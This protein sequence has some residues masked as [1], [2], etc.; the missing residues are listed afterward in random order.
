MIKLSSEQKEIVEA[1]LNEAVQVLASAGTGKTRVLT[2][3]IRFILKNTKRKRVIAITFTNK[4][5]QEM[6]SRLS[7]CNE[8]VER[9]WISTIHSFAEGVLRS[10]GHEIGLPKQ[11]QIFER[12]KDRMDIFIHALQTNWID[13]Y[14]Y[15]NLR[16]K[17]NKDVEYELREYMNAFSII[18]RELMDKT[19]VQLH[20]ADK[21][22]LWQI[23]QDYQLALLDSG[24]IDYDDLIVYALKLFQNEPW[25]VDIYRIMYKY[26]C[27][28]EAQDLNLLQYEFLKALCGDSIKSVMMVGDPNQMIYGFNGSSSTYLSKDF[29][30]DF[31]A[32]KFTLEQNYRSSQLI[33]HAANNLKPDAVHEKNSTII[34]KVVIKD[35]PDPIEEAKWII[36]KINQ[37]ITMGYHEEIEGNITL[38]R[39][40]VIARNRLV[41]SDLKK[42]LK[43][44]SIPY[45]M[46]KTDRVT[47]PLSSLGKILDYGIRV[48]LNPKDW[49]HG[50]KLCSVLSIE[51][52]PKWNDEDILKKFAHKVD[53][54][55]DSFHH[56]QSELLL[57]IHELDSSVPNIRK[58]KNVMYQKLI[59]LADRESAHGHDIERS[60]QELEEFY[61]NWMMFKQNGSTSSL[62]SFQSARALGNGVAEN[63]TNDSLMLSTV[64]TMK[65]LEKDIVFII[66]MCEGTFP[67]YRASNEHD[68]SEERN[69]AFVA[70]TRAKRWLF[71]SYPEKRRMPWGS[72]RS[73]VE[74]RFIKE[75][76]GENPTKRELLP[77]G[78]EKKH[79]VAY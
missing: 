5:A 66:S 4:A 10:Y 69:N 51:P 59:D 27:V 47:E 56:F 35:Q 21:P 20:F 64:H 52:P 36:S 6:Q 19:E 57:C 31:S 79:E 67:D 53:T 2:E 25:I 76:R 32:R 77:L 1:P 39:M 46:K 30:R 11:L 55:N 37:F 48:K 12:D 60:I 62:Y 75:I 72:E 63:V 33:I 41:F 61:S 68:I 9:A 43:E 18:K 70:V 26:I 58:L 78:L 22:E 54:P 13:M 34:G 23:F 50:K 74:S 15:L 73:V 3:R 14:E 8:V 44:N 24:G 71:I 28:D 16:K 49:V 17:D 38:N 65:G 29:V 7:D 42:A 45:F 40:V